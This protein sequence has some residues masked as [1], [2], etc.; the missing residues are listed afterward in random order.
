MVHGVLHWL[1]VEKLYTE[2]KILIWRLMDLADSW[3][4]G[5]CWYC[6]ICMTAN[7][8][9]I[10][11]QIVVHRSL[12]IITIDLDRYSGLSRLYLFGQCSSFSLFYVLFNIFVSI[13]YLHCVRQ[14]LSGSRL[15]FDEFRKS[16]HNNWN[17]LV[18]LSKE[19][20]RQ[21]QD[22]LVIRV[23]CNDTIG[24][25]W[26]MLIFI[27]NNANFPWYMLVIVY[28]SSWTTIVSENKAFHRIVLG[29][30][31][32]SLMAHNETCS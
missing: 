23:T 31:P 4:G 13:Y 15:A 12:L 29:L 26:Y 1:F 9:W 10:L 21:C 25:Y 6:C 20:S 19:V 24:L 30:T 22:V 27:S 28:V 14:F 7:R 18:R 3:W 11:Y 8:T 16:Q 5:A 17:N 32:E 2:K